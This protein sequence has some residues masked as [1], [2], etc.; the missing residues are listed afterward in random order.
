[1]SMNRLK[2]RIGF[3]KKKWARSFMPTLKGFLSSSFRC[4]WTDKRRSFS[5][6]LHN[7]SSKCYSKKFLK[8]RKPTKTPNKHTKKTNHKKKSCPV[9]IYN[10]LLAESTFLSTV[11]CKTSSEE[12]FALVGPQISVNKYLRTRKT[13]IS[14]VLVLVH[15]SKKKLLSSENPKA[16]LPNAI[17]YMAKAS[18]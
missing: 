5:I 7:L 2:K 17:F 6:S 1:M 12:S 16:Y 10:A 3:R 9:S 18:T 15:N 11:T 8:K 4:V 14:Y 13:L